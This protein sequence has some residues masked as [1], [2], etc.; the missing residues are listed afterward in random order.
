MEVLEP[1]VGMV[2]CKVVEIESEA[3]LCLEIDIDFGV[4][5][6]YRE[7]PYLDWVLGN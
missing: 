3:P 6:A 2:D 1:F 5:I 7:Q 4:E